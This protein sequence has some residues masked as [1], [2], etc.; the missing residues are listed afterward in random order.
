MKEQRALLTVGLST[1]VFGYS[2]AHL[3][4]AE[5]LI[6]AYGNDEWVRSIIRDISLQ[7]CCGGPFAIFI[8]FTIGFTIA[9]LVIESKRLMTKPAWVRFLIVGAVTWFAG[10][11]AY[12][13]WEF[14]MLLGAAL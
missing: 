5:T 10:F 14:I 12:C 2:L 8:G 9:S 11:A 3:L 4:F 1:S 7:L 6:Q 13:P